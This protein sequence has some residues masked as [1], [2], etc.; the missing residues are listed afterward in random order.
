MA[1]FSFSFGPITWILLTELFP[2]SMKAEAMSLGQAVSWTANVF[3][4]VT[5]L[6]A[7]RILSLP[8]VFFVYLVFALFAIGFIYK[9]IP[10]TKGKSLEDISKE[11]DKNIRTKIS[12]TDSK[13]KRS[14]ISPSFD[15]QPYQDTVF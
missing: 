10:E 11:L 3:V 12:N 9:F 15:I 5:F 8:F 14:I 6:D 7:V 1:A 2:V 13:M 4:S